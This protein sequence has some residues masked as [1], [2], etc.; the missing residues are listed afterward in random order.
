MTFA[1]VLDMLING[2]TIRRPTWA[3]YEDIYL[4]SWGDVIC[5]VT[6]TKSDLEATDWEVIE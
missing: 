2:S 1:E 3:S 4:S 5:D 6:L